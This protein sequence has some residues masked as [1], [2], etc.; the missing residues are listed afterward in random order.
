MSGALAT[1]EALMSSFVST[2]SLAFGL[3]IVACHF[4]PCFLPKS[5][6]KWQRV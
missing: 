1:A 5:G 6:S 2:E 3:A 4:K